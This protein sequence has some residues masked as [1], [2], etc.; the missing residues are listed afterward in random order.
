MLT[1]MV[2]RTER[3]RMIWSDASLTSMGGYGIVLSPWQPDPLAARTLC[4][5]AAE[6][7]AGTIIDPSGRL[8]W[9]P[10]WPLPHEVT[11]VPGDHFTVLESHA[12]TTAA[13]VR[14]WLASLT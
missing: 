10:S 4:V 8:D 2:E 5:R 3:Y 7:L 6:P 13:A 9:R 11:D 1:A 12:D 14:T